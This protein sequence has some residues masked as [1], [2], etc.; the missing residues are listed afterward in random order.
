M[1]PETSAIWNTATNQAVSNTVLVRNYYKYHTVLRKNNSVFQAFNYLTGFFFFQVFL[2]S[3]MK[4]I[5]LQKVLRDIMI[6]AKSD[7]PGKMQGVRKIR[8]I[9]MKQESP[10]A[11]DCST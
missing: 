9:K 10:A 5:H 4:G 2:P 7:K 1:S 8:K 6:S 11:R 3:E